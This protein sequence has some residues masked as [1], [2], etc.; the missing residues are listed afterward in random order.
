MPRTFFT[1]EEAREKIGHLVEARADFP[2]VPQ[3]SRG[4]VVKARKH[5]DDQW[6][7]CIEWEL[8]KTASHYEMT[9]GDASLNFFRKSKS[10]TDQFCK[11]DYE[12]LLHVIHKSN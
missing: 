9:F 3:G 5:S 7:A 8:P 11:S 12:T 1:S 2:S 6:L 4:R 10:V